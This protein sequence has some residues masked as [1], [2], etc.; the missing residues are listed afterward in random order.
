M[1]EPTYVAIVFGLATKLQESE[2]H[3]AALERNLTAEQSDMRAMQDKIAHLRT[4]LSERL[5]YE[6]EVES[7][8]AKVEKL[9]RDNARLSYDLLHGTPSDDSEPLTEYAN[10]YMKAEGKELYGK[11]E[12]IRTVQGI[13]AATGW[14]SKACYRF[15]EAFMD[16]PPETKRS[17]HGAVCVEVCSES[18]VSIQVAH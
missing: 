17:E 2:K 15:M 3:I 14:A 7:L 18:F 6:C 10:T 12:K 5:N 9:E 8:R 16:S 13:M 11:G 4:Q 1:H